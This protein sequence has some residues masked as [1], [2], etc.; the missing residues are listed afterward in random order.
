LCVQVSILTTAF[1]NKNE[2]SSADFKSAFER[3][4]RACGLENAYL[5]LDSTELFFLTKRNESNDPL[6]GGDIFGS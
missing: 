4:A 5:D 3:V 1:V 2:V 6:C